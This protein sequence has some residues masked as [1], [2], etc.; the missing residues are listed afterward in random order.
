MGRQSNIRQQVALKQAQGKAASQRFIELCEGMDSDRSGSLSLDK[1]V[2]GYESNEKDM[3][4]L[5]DIG[6]SDMEFVFGMPD[7]D[8]TGT[9]DNKEFADQLHRMK[10]HDQQALV[11]IRFY[12]ME[13][14]AKVTE[15]VKI[16]R[17]DLVSR[18]DTIASFV[19]AA[20]EDA[21]ALETNAK[22]CG[23]K[24]TKTESAKQLQT[25]CSNA[26][27]SDH[28]VLPDPRREGKLD[29]MRQDAQGSNVKQGIEELIRAMQ[30]I[31]AKLKEPRAHAYHASDCREVLCPH[32]IVVVLARR[33]SNARVWPQRGHAARLG[34]L[35]PQRC[36]LPVAKYDTR[37][38]TKNGI[39]KGAGKFCSAAGFPTS[40]PA[41]GMLH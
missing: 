19:G 18:M 34:R 40:S 31:V 14:R 21:P 23:E 35:R 29:I 30:E 12:V 41:S 16:T 8:S 38:T 26:E 24:L 11:F 20:K 36:S 15:H 27:S 33:P 7:S 4:D 13:I 1:P 5:M 37:Q 10:S 25:N 2:A 9:V 22:T 17:R 3:M 39:S 6:E 28:N 32:E